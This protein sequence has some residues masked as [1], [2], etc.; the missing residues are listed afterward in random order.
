MVISERVLGFVNLNGS[1][2]LSSNINLSMRFFLYTSQEVNLLSN[3]K[4]HLF[5]LFRHYRDSD[6]VV[7]IPS[8]R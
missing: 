7:V 3:W 6:L 1:E 2:R 4:F 5:V 8:R